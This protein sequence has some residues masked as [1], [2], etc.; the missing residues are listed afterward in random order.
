MS[1]GD[2]L[3]RARKEHR[4]DLCGTQIWAGTRYWRWATLGD[5]HPHE[6]KGHQSCCK[7][8]HLMGPGLQDFGD[9]YILEAW[10]KDINTTAPGYRAFHLARL[11]LLLEPTLVDL[12]NLEDD[13]LTEFRVV[14]ASI[15]GEW[16][17][18]VE[19]R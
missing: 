4:C 1:I 2:Q 3:R 19:I 9:D 11:L 17:M 5:D 14:A 10:L 16:A 18:H 13:H 6:N 15:V 12:A 8:V 7:L